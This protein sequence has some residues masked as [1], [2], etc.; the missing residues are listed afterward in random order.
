MP[1]I[2]DQLIDTRQ[3]SELLQIQTSTIEKARVMR[4]GIPYVKLGRSVR[5]KLSDV[6][7]H[8]DSKRV[9]TE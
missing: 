5:Y 4:R 3:L 1:A 8:I 9:A 2:T 7:S 6:L